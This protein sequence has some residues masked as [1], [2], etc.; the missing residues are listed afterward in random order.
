MLLTLEQAEQFV[1]NNSNTRWDNYD[2]VFHTPTPAGF[3]SIKGSF[4]P[5]IGW[6]IE[7]RVKPNRQGLWRIQ[8]R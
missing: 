5:G 1:Q 3:S 2:V 4:R 8:Q 6:G 7:S